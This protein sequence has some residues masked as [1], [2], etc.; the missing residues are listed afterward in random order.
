M[1][2]DDRQVPDEK[3]QCPKCESTYLIHPPPK[4]NEDWKERL[5]CPIPCCGYS[6]EVKDEN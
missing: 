5:F 6:T 3:I 4:Y 2:Q 1:I